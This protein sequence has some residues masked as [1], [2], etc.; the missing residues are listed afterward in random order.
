MDKGTYDNVISLRK[1]VV[2]TRSLVS[3][4]G[5]AEEA[6]SEAQNDNDPDKTN[7]KSSDADLKN[8]LRRDGTWSVYKYYYQSA[9]LVAFTTCIAFMIVEAV[10]GNFTS[11]FYT[12]LFSKDQIPG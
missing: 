11:M 2:A 5:I 9:G 10:S 1:P 6:L 7:T 8:P 12:L 4:E 3:T